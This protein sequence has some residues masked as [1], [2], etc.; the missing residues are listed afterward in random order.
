MERTRGLVQEVGRLREDIERKVDTVAG[1][2]GE[3]REMEA[4]VR[5]FIKLYNQSQNTEEVKA[6]DRI[7]LKHVQ[8]D[9]FEQSPPYVLIF[10]GVE[11]DW[12]EEV[13]QFLEI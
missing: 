6:E 5:D 8:E 4:V 13:S 2:E 10:I 12:M 3:L 7:V 11:I 9:E 1:L